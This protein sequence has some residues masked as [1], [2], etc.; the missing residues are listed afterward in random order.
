MENIIEQWLNALEKGQLPKPG[1]E[2]QL[3]RLVQEYPWSGLLVVLHLMENSRK[4]GQ[5]SDEQLVGAALAVQD[6]M[7]LRQLLSML[8]APEAEVLTVPEADAE[9]GG[10]V[11][12]NRDRILEEFLQ[13][14]PRIVPDKESDFS[15]S[16]NLAQESL[17]EDPDLIS[18]TLARI[19]ALQ[20]NKE[21][22]RR[23]YEKLSL[24]YPEK[25]AYFAALI[26]GLDSQ[27]SNPMDNQTTN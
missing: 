1:Q 3:D 19:Y 25:S 22:A 21:K 7:K 24:K 18:E 17:R 13:K 26:S 16:A 2:D 6:R 9:A 8:P 23:I 5:V 27:E 10:V 20:G 11:R 14:E 12:Q 15:E 4:A